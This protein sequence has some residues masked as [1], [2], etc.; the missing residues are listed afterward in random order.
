MPQHIP[1][2]L[3]WRRNGTHVE[4]V[5]TIRFPYGEVVDGAEV[6]HSRTPQGAQGKGR[7]ESQEARPQTESALVPVRPVNQFLVGQSPSDDSINRKIEPFRVIQP[8]AVIETKC[9]FVQIPEQVERFD[10]D[11]RAMNPAL[12]QRPET[13]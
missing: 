12:Q 9:L 5:S 13:L 4:R 10:A 1:T 2:A 7:A 8:L 6:G 3:R 11:V